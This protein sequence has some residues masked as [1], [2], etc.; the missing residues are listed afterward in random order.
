MKTRYLLR[1]L[2]LS[3]ILCFSA[4]QLKAQS[5]VKVYRVSDAKSFLKALHSNSH[6]YIAKNSN[7]LLSDILEDENKRAEL[8]LVLGEAYAY[9]SDTE[10][11]SQLFCAK[12][13]DGVELVLNGIQNITIEAEGESRARILVSPRYAN[14][15]SF[16]NCV[17]VKLVNLEIGHTEEGYCEGGVLN[18][19]DCDNIEVKNCE[20]FGCGTIGVLAKNSKNFRCISSVICH[21]SYGIISLL[22]G[23]RNFLFKDCHMHHNREFDLIEVRDNNRGIVF[24]NCRIERNQGILFSLQSIVTLK[25]C[26]V[27][28]EGDFGDID[29]VKRIRGMFHFNPLCSE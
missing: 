22:P 15:L 23:N 6:I 20:L 29:R 1:T 25:D 16:K 12:V 28:N 27:N 14:V 2:L 18:L 17:N 24:D 21:C 7:L 3:F 26:Y 19:I 5:D 8:D 11:F 10:S 9:D 13:H 4:H